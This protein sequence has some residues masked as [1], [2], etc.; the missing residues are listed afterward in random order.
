MTE[1]IQ[2]PS[3]EP[4]PACYRSFAVMHLSELLKTEI[5]FSPFYPGFNDTIRKLCGTSRSTGCAIWRA[6]RTI[7]VIRVQFY[8]WHACA[9][10][11]SKRYY[12]GSASEDRTLVSV[13]SCTICVFHQLRCPRIFSQKSLRTAEAKQI[14]FQFKLPLLTKIIKILIGPRHPHISAIFPSKL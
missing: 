12:R 11:M 14:T 4:L 7:K 8:G 1:W 9:V 3:S 10:Q 5:C 6:R 2:I 13:H